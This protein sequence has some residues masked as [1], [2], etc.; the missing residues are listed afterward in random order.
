MTR[1]LTRVTLDNTP[2][3]KKLDGTADAQGALTTALQRASFVLSA[4]ES[5]DTLDYRYQRGLC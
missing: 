2:A 3:R 4:E 1:R 5:R